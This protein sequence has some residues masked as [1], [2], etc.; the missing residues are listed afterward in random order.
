M[1]GSSTQASLTYYEYNGNEAGHYV[2]L[3]SS[4]EVLSLLPLA[5]LLYQE[6]QKGLRM[7]RSSH[8]ISTA[9]PARPGLE[10]RE[11]G[12]AR[13]AMVTGDI[14]GSPNM[15]EFRHASPSSLSYSECQPHRP[16][17]S[18]HLPD[19]LLAQHLWREASHLIVSVSP[20][21]LSLRSSDSRPASST[22]WRE[23]S[24]LIVSDSHTDLSLRSSARCP[25]SSTLVARDVPSYSECQ[26]HRPRR[27]DHLPDVLLAQH[28][29]REAS[30]LIV[31]V[32][33]TD[34]S[35][36]SSDSRPASPTLVARD[37][38]SYNHLTAGLPARH[39]WRETSHLIVSD[40]HTDLSLRSSDSWPASSTLV[41]RDVPSYNHL[42]A[43]LPA[44]HLWRETSHL[45]VSDSHTDLSL[46]SS[47]SWPASSTLVARDVPSYNH[48]TAGLPARH[49]WRET[50]HLIVSVSPT[51]LSLRSSDSRPASPTLVARDVPSYSEC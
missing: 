15:P 47:D 44:R 24:H 19:V 4:M 1:P 21:D 12:G 25:A 10:V 41:A 8:Q 51:D 20:T 45:I 34:L 42:T 36:R 50:S 31:S 26:P 30:H 6:P 35:L 48:L 2:P 7:S 32:S 13:L 37:V 38:P 3:L 28:L 23:T 18:D 39:L 27:S 22:L 17:R 43:G 40:S 5:P 11:M 33:P 16:R 29:W 14:R 49:L 46:R 9:G